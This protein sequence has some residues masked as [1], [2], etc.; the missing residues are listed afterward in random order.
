MR[1]IKLEDHFTNAKVEGARASGRLR[2]ITDSIARWLE[3]NRAV[4]IIRKAEDRNG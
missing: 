3:M 1:R 4:E 2:E